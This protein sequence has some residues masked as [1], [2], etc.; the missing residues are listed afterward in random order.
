MGINLITTG[1]G[2]MLGFK[3]KSLRLKAEILRDHG[4]SKKIRY[5][6]NEIGFNFRLT[7][8]QSAVGV[9]QLEK[10]KKL[11]KNKKKLAFNYKKIFK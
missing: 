10:I 6:H 1:E 9:A 3:Q 11:L 5:W 8:I 7:N 2:G 4:M